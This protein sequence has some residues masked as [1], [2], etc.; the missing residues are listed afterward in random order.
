MSHSKARLMLDIG[1]QRL[2]MKQNQRS[3]PAR[4][5]TELI[6]QVAAVVA[7]EGPYLGVDYFQAFKVSVIMMIQL[8]ELID[9]L[10][11]SRVIPGWGECIIPDA[12]GLIFAALAG[13]IKA[14]GNRDPRAIVR[15]MAGIVLERHYGM[16]NGQNDVL[17]REDVERTMRKYSQPLGE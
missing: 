15:M 1:L 7:E 12:P 3:T 14:K 9:P 2:T 8:S 11:D 17:A 4:T 6:R 10:F 13:R 5:P 16:P